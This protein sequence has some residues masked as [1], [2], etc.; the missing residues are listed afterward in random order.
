M[1]T[2]PSFGFVG[3]VLKVRFKLGVVLNK[4]LPTVDFFEI[5]VN[6]VLQPFA[7]R[8]LAF[9]QP[10]VARGSAASEKIE[11]PSTF[12]SPTRKTLAFGDR[13]DDLQRVVL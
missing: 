1:S 13:D 11:L 12:S 6:S 7:V 10:D 3:I 5:F 4:A 2:I 9:L 8:D